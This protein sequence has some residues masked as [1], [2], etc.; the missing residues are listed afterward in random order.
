[1]IDPRARV[2]T[3]PAAELPA[4][5]P[6]LLVVDDQPI[7]IQAMYKVF[8]ADHQLFVAT[9]GEQALAFCRRDPP[10]LILLDVAMPGMDGL[11]VCRRLKS[12]PQLR[13]IP[14]IFVTAYDS[15]LEEAHGLEA[16]AVD[17]ISKPVNPAVVRARVNTHLT[18]KRQ[19][20]LLRNMA[21]VDG[22]TGVANRRR[23]DDT[24]D[25]EWRRCRRNRTPLALLMIDID[26]FKQY[27]DSYGH[28]AGDNCLRAVAHA[29]RETLARSHDQV[30]RYGGEEFACLLPD[31]DLEG[32]LETA[33]R[34]RRAVCD[35]R[36]PH[37]DSPVASVVTVSLG[38]A[39]TVP[40]A[41]PGPEALLA[42]ADAR[43][44]AAKQQ[45]RNRVCAGRLPHKNPA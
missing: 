30:A 26:C 35:L 10:D 40:T 45:G 7:N 34:V 33:E 23:L 21:F 32:A 2:A 12:D 13:E 5:Q 14:V 22:L 31:T 29:V 15:P 3:S 41:A 27:N 28:Q 36:V 4:P 25:H 6:R 17:F 16:G 18:L 24:L 44:Y 19:A 39:V 38:V 20:D 37:K 1:M 11:E 8:A 43:L 42:A 9:S